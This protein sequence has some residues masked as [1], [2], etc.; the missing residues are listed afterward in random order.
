MH[1]SEL[2][3]LE[4]DAF[5]RAMAIVEQLPPDAQRALIE[6]AVATSLRYDRERD[7]EVLASWS[8]G[9]LQTLRLHA[10]AQFAETLGEVAKFDRSRRGVGLSGFVASLRR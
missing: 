10:S 5:D 6:H 4:R 8:I 7:P 2:R 1:K 9:L 3:S